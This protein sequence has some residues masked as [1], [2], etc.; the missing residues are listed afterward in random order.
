[1]TAAAH[2]V[3]LR[4]FDAPDDV[5]VMTKGRFELD[6][7]GLGHDLSPSIVAAQ[8]AGQHVAERDRAQEVRTDDESRVADHDTARRVKRRCRTWRATR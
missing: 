8:E 7:I 3:I 1:M 6:H 5:R 4:R 2:D